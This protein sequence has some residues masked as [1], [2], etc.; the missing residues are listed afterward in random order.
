MEDKRQHIVWHDDV[1][2]KQLISYAVGC[3]MGRYSLDKPGLILAN[4][5]DGMKEFR[6]LVPQSRFEP[7]DD[8]IIPLM[9][10]DSGMGDNATIR[11]SAWM[12]AAF[13]K[14]TLVENLNFVEKS[15]GKSIDDYFMRDFWADH[16]KM[17]QNRP[18]YWLFSS[19]KG[20]FKCITYMHR[21]TPYTADQVRAN[22]LLPY[23]ERQ[24]QRLAEM[25]AQASQLTT[26]G[27]KEMDRLGKTIKE[28]VE[29]HERLQALAED[30]VRTAFDLDDGVEKNYAKYGD[31]LA[32]L[33]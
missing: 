4:Q 22:Y 5:G 18:I 17:Y 19:K 11:F 23:I 28:C 6:A 1:V 33:K 10:A 29:Y 3:M 20:A 25:T 13:G 24:R 31:V 16:K 12:S 8:G 30:T 7:D 14:D 21:M 26:A 15:L 32:K 9:P 2:I 27:R